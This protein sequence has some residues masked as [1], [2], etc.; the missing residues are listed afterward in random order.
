MLPAVR[1]QHAPRAFQHVLQPLVQ[2]MLFPSID[3][4][5]KAGE[6]GETKLLADG[7]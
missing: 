6:R 2:A 3:S 4:Q 7:E 1:F 5:T